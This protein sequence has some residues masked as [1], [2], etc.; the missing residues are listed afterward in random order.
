MLV[1]A[2]SV[3]PLEEKRGEQNMEDSEVVASSLPEEFMPKVSTAITTPLSMSDPSQPPK[4]AVPPAPAIFAPIL[5]ITMEEQSWYM[6]ELQDEDGLLKRISGLVMHDASMVPELPDALHHLPRLSVG[7]PIAIEDMNSTTPTTT[8]TPHDIL[9]EISLGVDLFAS[10]FITSATEGGIA[11]DFAFP[12]PRT[13]QTDSNPTDGKSNEARPL[14]IDLHNPEHATAVQPIS[15]ECS[16]C[17]CKNHHRAY[18][19]HL[20]MAQE[21]LAWVL[22]QVHN[23]RVVD[24]FF[25]GVRE[26]I[27]KGER[28]FEEDRGWFERCYEHE[29]PARTGKGPR[30]VLYPDLFY[31]SSLDRL[32]FGALHYYAFLSSHLVYILP[33]TAMPHQVSLQRL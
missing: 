29:M 18:I 26:S 13:P 11:L 6:D 14:G 32:L 2:C 1:E 5:P 7:G 21:M 28:V 31:I 16:C 12:A 8:V 17:T 20:L 25:A 27:G 9:R 4:E 24:E 30:Y 23:F 10:S 19:H 33:A 15:E 22:L 3:S